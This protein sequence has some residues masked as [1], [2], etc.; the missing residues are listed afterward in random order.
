MMLALAL[1]MMMAGGQQGKSPVSISDCYVACRLANGCTD[2]EV[3]WVCPQAQDVP[4]IQELCSNPQGC[5]GSAWTC[6]DKS[7][8]LLTGEDG[9]HHCIKFGDGE[10]HPPPPTLK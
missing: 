1:W 5:Q 6:A 4:A 2:R 10:T 7:R 3:E 8:V 9:Q